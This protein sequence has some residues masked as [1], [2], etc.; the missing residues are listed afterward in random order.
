M[1]CW[2][3][4]A[5]L[6]VL[7]LLVLTV[8]AAARECVDCRQEWPEPDT[9]Y[10]ETEAAVEL[11]DKPD[12]S[13]QKDACDEEAF[14]EAWEVFHD[15]VWKGWDGSGETVYIDLSEYEIPF[16]AECDAWFR[17]A[18]SH[19]P[20]LFAME[21]WQYYCYEYPEG[22]VLAGIEPIYK[23]MALKG[24]V[25][26]Q[27]KYD[28]AKKV[29]TDGVQE[30]LQQVDRKW[31]EAEQLLFLHD[32][33][34]VN[35]E[36]D[37]T[38]TVKDAYGF[39]AQKKGVCQAYTMVF[40]A[41]AEELGFDISYVESDH[42][43]HIWNLVELDDNWYHIDVTWDDPTE[44]MLGFAQHRY[45]LL[46][47]LTSWLRHKHD[48]VDST[49][50]PGHRFD[51]VYGVDVVCWDNS[52][53][54]A[55]WSIVN[56]PFVYEKETG[57][58]YFV[59]ADGLRSWNP[60]EQT[61]SGVL[62]GFEDVRL[63]V[64]GGAFLC[65]DQPGFAGLSLYNGKLFY[66]SRYTVRSYEPKTGAVEIL[67]TLDGLELT[68]DPEAPVL[69]KECIL[70]LRV[71][72]GVLGY[73]TYSFLTERQTYGELKVGSAFTSVGGDVYSYLVE[74]DTLELQVDRGKVLVVCYNAQGA[75]SGMMICEKSGVYDLPEGRVVL[76][77][78]D[79][80]TGWSPLCEAV[81]LLTKN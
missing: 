57:L 27:E 34:A 15:H 5:V 46:D 40:M 54:N 72:D 29:Y 48:G 28:D 30:I 45:F 77:A 23:Q 11:L 17:E 13:R 60:K 24:G 70:S 76:F 51:W 31:S 81:P 61:L 78:V 38:Y 9:V 74:E 69:E 68:E 33:L 16:T 19:A 12:D 66:N 37:E 49:D 53:I 39:F 44:D 42:L 41:V 71:E 80:D 56:S 22:K 47:D 55:F 62:D 79:G 52:Y 21:E 26:D 67:L 4:Y 3:K 2:K 58:W 59:D 75:M 6:S 64:P 63:E 32:Y 8:G 50:T 35:F 73:E 14:E 18:V 36:Y 1:K 10:L 43:N 25:F 65:P 20:D 7:A